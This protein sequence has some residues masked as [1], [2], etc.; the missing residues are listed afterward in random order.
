MEL[1]ELKAIRRR[2]DARLERSLRLNAALLERSKLRKSSGRLLWLTAG[3]SLEAVLTLIAALLIGSFAADHLR[4]PRFFVPALL[5]GAYAIAIFAA[6]L[7][8]IV[9]L[10]SI[11]YARPV[12]TVG[13]GSRTCACFEFARR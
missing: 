12:V 10:G 2:N 5:L 3:I 8:Q 4:E 9:D 6:N 11:D 13:G 7:R 1:D